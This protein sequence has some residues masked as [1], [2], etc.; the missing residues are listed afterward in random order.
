MQPQELMTLLWSLRQQRLITLQLGEDIPCNDPN[1]IVETTIVYLIPP[2]RQVYE[3]YNDRSSHQSSSS[4]SNSN[5]NCTSSSTS[6]STFM[7]KEM[8]ENG[9][10]D[11]N[12]P[13]NTPS[14]SI[15]LY[16]RLIYP[17]EPPKLL[18]VESIR[19]A[20]CQPH[21]PIHRSTLSTTTFYAGN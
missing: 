21:L 6:S 10:Y 17:H 11:S 2:L 19:R 13:R 3:L 12:T 8:S 18:I 20:V 7:E 1:S 14:H 5:S 9:I 4:N 16:H 15:S